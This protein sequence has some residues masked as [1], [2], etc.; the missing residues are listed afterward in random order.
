MHTDYATSGPTLHLW[1][2]FV[3]FPRTHTFQGDEPGLVYRHVLATW[4]EPSPEERERAMGFQTGITSHTKV[5][6]VERNALLGR[7][8][9]LNSLTWLLVTYV[10]FQ[11]YIT[12]TLIQSTWSSG[13]ATMW[14][15]DR[16][17][18]PIF[19]I[20]YF[21]LS[22]GGEDIPCNL[23]QVVSDTPKGT[24]VYGVIII[25]FYGSMQL[26]SGESNTLGSSNTLS[27]SIPCISNYLFVMGNQLTKKE[28]D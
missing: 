13:D 5:T 25:T 4:D 23:T 12:P 10:L 2:T 26:D 20:L 3:S 28:R 14:H 1:P 19:N 17:H 9:D 18:L 21:T 11:M 16:V 6:R 15:P 8:M 27:N 7:S 22:V 24:L